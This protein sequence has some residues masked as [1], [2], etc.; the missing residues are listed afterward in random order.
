MNCRGGLTSYS[1]Q[2]AEGVCPT[3]E[4]RKL[5]NIL[6][7]VS[8]FDFKGK[9]LRPKKEKTKEL[10]ENE[11]KTNNKQE[12]KKEKQHKSEVQPPELLQAAVI[13][14]QYV[15]MKVVQL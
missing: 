1:Q 6:K 9:I 14:M 13:I 15:K 8:L 3:A 4:M 11:K 12:Y 2:G 7:A 10:H 5:P